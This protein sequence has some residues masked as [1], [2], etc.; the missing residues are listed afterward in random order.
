MSLH[1][2]ERQ[3]NETRAK[4]RERQAK[5]RAAVQR[6]TLTGQHRPPGHKEPNGREIYRRAVKLAA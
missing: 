2:P 4:Y 3:P 6:M 1:T 5:S